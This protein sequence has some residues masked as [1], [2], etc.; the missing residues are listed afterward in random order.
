MLQ[1]YDIVEV[2]KNKKSIAQ[3]ILDIVTGASRTALSSVGN[4]LGTRVLY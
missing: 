1:P 3:T 2:D 4:G